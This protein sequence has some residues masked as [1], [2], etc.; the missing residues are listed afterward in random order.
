MLHFV[1]DDVDQFTSSL[2]PRLQD[3]DLV[4][5]SGGVSAGA[6]EVVKDALRGNGVQFAK[7]AM[8]PGMPQGAG[9]I[10]GIPVVCLPGNPVSSYVSFE[11]FVRPALRTAMGFRDTRRPMVRAALGESLE[12]PAGKRQFRRGLFDPA[13]AEVMSVGPFGSHFLRSLADANCLIDIEPAVTDLAAGDR[14]DVWL[15]G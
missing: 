4:I 10:G 5:T 11:V 15:L 12:S 3:V 2:Y 7:V 13:T 1:A 6:Y 8:Q 14:V 9:S